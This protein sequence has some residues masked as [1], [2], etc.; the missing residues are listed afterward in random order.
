MGCQVGKKKNHGKASKDIFCE[1]FKFKSNYK[2]LINKL[3]KQINN[4]KDSEIFINTERMY[5]I[6]EVVD[7]KIFM[8]TFSRFT[9]HGVVFKA[10]WIFFS[11]LPRAGDI[12]LQYEIVFIEFPLRLHY[13]STLSVL[14]NFVFGFNE[15]IRELHT[16]SALF[17]SLVELLIQNR[18]L[19]LCHQLALRDIIRNSHKK[20]TVIR[21][22]KIL[23]ST[24][25]IHLYENSRK[26]FFQCPITGQIGFL[27][28]KQ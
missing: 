19:E 1:I 11:F 26:N 2:L 16:W 12:F 14:L 25:S 18:I 20:D 13:K 6:G 15:A 27:L 4:R 10:S 24:S 7:T 23:S 3:Y 17:Q 28:S 9:N 22:V 21:I 8:L 5:F